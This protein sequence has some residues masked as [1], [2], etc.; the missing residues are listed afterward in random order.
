M[1]EAIP[2]Y[3][4]LGIMEIDKIDLKL[5]VLNGTSE[6]IL[7]IGAGFLEGTTA[8]GEPG[9]TVLTAH[10]SHTYGRFFNRLDELEVGIKLLSHDR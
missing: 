5:P 4:T 3:E 7:R 8:I 9:N 6:A 2:S 1:T 10:R